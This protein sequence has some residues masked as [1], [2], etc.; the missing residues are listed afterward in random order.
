MLL[1]LISIL[2]LKK[3]YQAHKSNKSDISIYLDL[4]KYFTDLNKKIIPKQ[5]RFFI[6]YSKADRLDK[7]H[8]LR[9][10]NIENLELI[11]YNYGGHRLIRALRDN[12]ELDNI[13]TKSFG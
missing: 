10:N 12:G 13:F 8:A 6:H 9:L 5:N 4:K 2:Q 3:V 1:I 7:I 11:G